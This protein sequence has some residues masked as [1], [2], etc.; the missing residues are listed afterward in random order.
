MQVDLLCILFCVCVCIRAS[1]EDVKNVS[2]E[3]GQAMERG[4]RGVGE[5][6]RDRERRERDRNHSNLNY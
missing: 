4:R 1:V 2:I 6:E 3:R 5:R